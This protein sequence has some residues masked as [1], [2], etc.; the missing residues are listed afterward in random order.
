MLTLRESSDLRFV[1]DDVKSTHV[2]ALDLNSLQPFFPSALAPEDSPARPKDSR[3]YT[4]SR[5]YDILI[6]QN[7]LISGPNAVPEVKSL[8][9][10]FWHKQALLGTVHFANLQL[11]HSRKYRLSTV[12]GFHPQFFNFV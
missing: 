5:C 1:E 3:R 12:E 4:R 6:A 7:L 11:P 9:D 8:Q 10:C 2:S